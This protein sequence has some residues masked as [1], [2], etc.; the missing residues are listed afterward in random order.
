MAWRGGPRQLAPSAALLSARYCGVIRTAARATGERTRGPTAGRP[1][2]GAERAPRPPPELDFEPLTARKRPCAV[3]PT[4]EAERRAALGAGRVG[5]RARVP[6]VQS[7]SLPRDPWEIVFPGGWPIAW[8]HL[9]S[10]YRA[11]THPSRPSAP[12]QPPIRT[13]GMVPDTPV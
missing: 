6:Q 10:I 3:R 9:R 4:R 8:A 12:R 2:H 7:A 1:R 13:T 11:G 5:G